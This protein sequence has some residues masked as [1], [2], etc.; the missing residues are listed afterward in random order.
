MSN[1]NDILDVA[2]VYPGDVEA[3]ADQYQQEKVQL[4]TYTT[5]LERKVF[6]LKQ[7][8][9]LVDPVV[10]SVEV[11]STQITQW[12]EFVKCFPDESGD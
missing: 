7:L 12:N 4:I 8:M 9:L 10:L 3:K 2:R 1:V 5:E 6:K 11:G